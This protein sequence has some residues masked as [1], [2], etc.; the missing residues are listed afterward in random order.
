M[1]SHF[2]STLYDQD[3]FYRQFHKDIS[4]AHKRLIVES[5]FITTRRVASLL[6]ILAKLRRRGVDIIINT[7]PLS[8]HTTGLYEQALE[9]VSLLQDIGVRVLFTNG[10][11]RKLAVIDYSILYEG[12]LNILS[13][14]DSC[15]I[16]RRIDDKTAVSEMIRFIKL[17]KWCK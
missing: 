7:K 13:Q 10:H 11:H 9:S 2:T 8:E 12:S 17:E 16:M 14:N 1:R 15:E 5:S 3:S 4:R 6:P